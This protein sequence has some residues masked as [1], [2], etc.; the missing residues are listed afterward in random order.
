MNESKPDNQNAVVAA[1]SEGVRKALELAR[2]AIGDACHATA[3][4]GDDPPQLYFD[5]LAAIRAALAAPPQRDLTKRR[6]LVAALEKRVNEEANDY[7]FRADDGSYTPNEKERVLLLDFGHGLLSAF[8]EILDAAPPQ[9]SGM[10]EAPHC[11]LLS[12]S[13][14]IEQCANEVP[15]SWLDPL[16]TGPDAVLRGAGPWGCPDIEALLRAVQARM[17][18]LSAHPPTASPDSPEHNPAAIDAQMK[19]EKT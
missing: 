10:E 11:L 12:E 19:G 15:T 9:Q 5:A 18:E 6:H 7:E 8:L 3:V 2:A 1:P 16:L 14:W 4:Y 13:E 17:R